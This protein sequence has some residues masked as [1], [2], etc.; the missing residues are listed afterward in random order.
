MCHHENTE[1]KHLVNR[2]C[3]FPY[4]LQK[5]LFNKEDLVNKR[6]RS[7][8]SLNQLSKWK[9]KALVF[10]YTW[11]VLL[12]MITCQVL[13]VFIAIV[14]MLTKCFKKNFYRYLGWRG[15]E[16]DIIR[17]E[18]RILDLRWITAGIF[19]KIVKKVGSCSNITLEIKQGS[20]LCL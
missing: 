9:K 6:E 10:C 15:Q 8:L 3:K 17:I 20:K 5:C 4:L 18:F 14:L 7:V 13:Q 2:E 11:S 19:T 1:I 12:S 16:E